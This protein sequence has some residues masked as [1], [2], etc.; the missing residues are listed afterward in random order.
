MSR[1]LINAGITEDR[2]ISIK[3]SKDM[4]VGLGGYNNCPAIGTHFEYGK[5]GDK[6]IQTA[7][8]KIHASCLLP[9]HVGIGI[10]MHR[11]LNIGVKGTQHDSMP[12][13]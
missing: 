7:Y 3:I 11:E 4:T 1:V 6:F 10:R 5:H 9:S 12:S 13:D 2:R 8:Y